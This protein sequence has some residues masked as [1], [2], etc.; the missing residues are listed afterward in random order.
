MDPLQIPL[1]LLAYILAFYDAGPEFVSVLL[2]FGESPHVGEASSSQ[3][4]VSLSPGGESSEYKRRSGRQP[5][6]KVKGQ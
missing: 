5:S 3:M 6:D 1:R 4:N 2:S